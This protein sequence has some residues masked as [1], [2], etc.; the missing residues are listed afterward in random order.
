MTSEV[1]EG[2]LFQF[3]YFLNIFLKSNLIKTLYKA[4]SLKTQFFHELKYD[5]KIC[6]ILLQ[7]QL[8]KK[9]Q[10]NCKSKSACKDL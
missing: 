9:R 8:K 7:L 4:N 5:F 6:F 3:Q 10:C 2:L 1:M